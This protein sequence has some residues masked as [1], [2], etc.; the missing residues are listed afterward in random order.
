MLLAVLMG[1]HHHCESPTDSAYE[2]NWNGATG[3][4][5]GWTSRAVPPMMLSMA[6][7]YFLEKGDELESQTA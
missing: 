6:V 2:P 7:G 4:A 1:V 3:R 5:R